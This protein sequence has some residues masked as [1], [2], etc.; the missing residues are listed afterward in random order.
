MDNELDKLLDDFA[1][2]CSAYAGQIQAGWS[3]LD[4]VMI[5]PK[6]RIVAS[7]AAIHKY[8]EYRYNP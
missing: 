5:K 1:S 2:A 4:T 7:R 3:P 8:L 6:E